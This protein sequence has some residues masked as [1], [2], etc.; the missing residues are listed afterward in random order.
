MPAFDRILK[1]TLQ[2]VVESIKS[3]GRRNSRR[4]RSHFHQPA[5]VLENR[6][7]L[8]VANFVIEPTASSDA[9]RAA[10]Q[11]EWSDSSA[12]AD[13]TYEFWVD[14]IL[15]G[16]RRNSRIYYERDI[17]QSIVAD[18]LEQTMTYV[19]SVE[20]PAG[21]YIGYLRSHDPDGPNHWHRFQVQIDDDGNPSTPLGDVSQHPAPEITVV[22]EGQGW[23]GQSSTESAVGWTSDSVLH[24]IWLNH[25]TE[26]SPWQRYRLIRNVTGSS[27]TFSELAAANQNGWATYFGQINA[28][29]SDFLDSGEYRLFIRSVN[30]A[31]DSQGQWDGNSLWSDPVDFTYQRIE[32]QA[33]RPA[34]LTA[35]NELRTQIQWTPVEAAEGY[36][37][38]IW[39][40]PNYSAH[41]PLF[42]RTNATSLQP[43]GHQFDNGKE[44]LSIA[45]GDELFIKVRGIGQ[46][47][48]PVSFQAG[49]FAS[50]TVRIPAEASTTTL[51]APNILGPVGLTGNS[52]PLL[53]W[54]DIGNAEHYE[55]WLSSL[56]TGRR[57]LLAENV[58]G[59]QL[60]IDDA[61]LT[62]VVTSSVD[63]SVYSATD[64]LVPG[65]YRFWVRAHSS[66]SSAQ[67]AWSP[68]NVFE[69]SATANAALDL[70]EDL[71]PAQRQIISPHLVVTHRETARDFILVATGKGE[72]FGRSVLAKYE[73]GSDGIPFRP[74]LTA[75]SGQSPLEFPDLPMGSNVTD[76]H[77]LSDG[78][79]AVLSRGSSELRLINPVSWHVLSTMSLLPGSDVVAPD[80]IGMEVLDNDQILVVFNRSHR[81]RLFEVHSQTLT[82][83][84][85]NTDE[86]DPEGF[87]LEHGRA[88]HV[89]AIPTGDG[90]YRIFAA[91]SGI[92][93]VTAY[94]YDSEAM[95]LEV[96]KT[97]ADEPLRVVRSSSSNPFLGGTI[98][99]LKL[100]TNEVRP[101]FLS[102]DRSGFL[103]WIDSVTLQSG[104][105]DMADWMPWA[106]RD[107]D[108]D[109]Y[110]NPD[111]NSYDTTRIITFGD[112]QIAVF[113]NR[114]NSLLL[115]LQMS[116]TG[117]V[118]VVSGSESDLFRGTSGTV[119]PTADGHQ[120][121]VT[122]TAPIVSEVS[123]GV[124]GRQ[125]TT[126]ALNR[127]TGETFYEVGSS[128]E[129]V[130]SNPVK[131]AHTI[132]NRLLVQSADASWKMF[133]PPTSGQNWSSIEWPT[134]L[135]WQD[136]QL[137]MSTGFDS[138]WQDPATMEFYVVLSVDDP[139][140]VDHR[141]PIVAIAKLNPSLMPEV[142]SVHRFP[143]LDQITSASLSDQ[144][145]ILVDRRHGQSMT[146]EDWRS[147][148]Q[149][150]FQQ[151]S[152]AETRESE[153]GQIRAGHAIRLNDETAAYVHDTFPDRGVSVFGSRARSTAVF[154][155]NTTG[156]FAFDLHRYDDDRI[157]M[158]TY[159]GDL[160]I[161]NAATGI[162][163]LD[164]PLNQFVNAG[165]T[166]SAVENSS[167][168]NGI[169]SVVSPA[170]QTVA[171]F[172]VAFID[173]QWKVTPTDVYHTPDIVRSIVKDE[174]LWIIETSQVR[175]IAL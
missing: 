125:L 139:A 158:A 104:F 117:R 42:L 67:S 172:E 128:T 156:T 23:F 48:S 66:I 167:F 142:I 65:R 62:G 74:T 22:R 140:E 135:D 18:D 82:E 3:V 85:V 36:L 32:G 163:E 150:S 71:P 101:V 69:V 114:A 83:V 110:V 15:P 24:D 5:E 166:L 108:S 159:G 165:I 168:E 49:N 119:L 116:D 146:I 55:I 34:E 51:P 145:L 80:A 77:M 20:Y 169:L 153:F 39:K 157:L 8:S 9:N 86:N 113:S 50:T 160:V 72:S 102:A 118:T 54:E 96:V 148:G 103:T 6:S 7:L 12:T 43:I 47:G 13:T 112:Q 162:V 56:E 138:V 33:A 58:E 115:Q 132:G 37:V 60:R 124:E 46:D 30:R 59:A 78:T 137:S 120:L 173:S 19:S 143:E 171:L 88:V 81:L 31:V 161:Q 129:I 106:S 76:M 4:R 35:T 75:S 17:S 174:T 27:I 38:S 152:F 64:G 93:A 98:V 105:I 91:T 29:A 155:P 164:L 28:S 175:R 123:Q 1:S 21:N 92:H 149:E 99:E 10:F 16:G 131:K 25:R 68:G 73:V 144:H 11:F 84:D 133:T 45:P 79:M 90:Q 141:I 2:S 127:V 97:Q 151:Y 134:Q 136:R 61:T 87:V 111:D 100:P 52:K 126:T 70:N 53:R 95:T 121:F 57:V 41:R 44:T 154:H 147:A 63:R 14:E 40:G 107:P 89:S 109:I 130:V 26:G 170:N 122:G 94:D